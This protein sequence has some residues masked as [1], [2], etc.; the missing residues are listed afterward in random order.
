MITKYDNFI[1]EYVEFVKTDRVL[2][3]RGF[4]NEFYDYVVPFLQKG[5]WYRIKCSIPRRKKEMY[6]VSTEPKRKIGTRNTKKMLLF[7]I[8]FNRTHSDYGSYYIQY[9]KIYKNGKIENVDPKSN[10]IFFDV[11]TDYEDVVF[12]HV[13]SSELKRREEELRKLNIKH[14]PYGEEEWND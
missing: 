10:Y 4:Y 14:D 5:E 7:V 1:N 9:D 13:E 3:L 2:K 6:V 12:E 11:L 8:R